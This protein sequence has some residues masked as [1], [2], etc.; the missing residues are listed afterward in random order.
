MATQGTLFQQESIQDPDVI[1]KFGITHH[2]DV[3]D[4]FSNDEI[5]K[6]Y[7]VEVI[8]S[9]WLEA[10]EASD[11]EDEYC[12]KY[13]KSLYN[14]KFT[15]FEGKQV[16]GQSEMRY[17]DDAVMNKI[18]YDFYK[19]KRVK[20]GWDE[21]SKQLRKIYSNNDLNSNSNPDARYPYYCYK[22]YIVVLLRKNS[23]GA[24]EYR[25]MMKERKQKWQENEAKLAKV[26]K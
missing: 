4:R 21:K 9:Q 3:L 6:E 25:E 20:R 2:Y 19:I 7:D 5:L 14:F 26:A 18:K 13:S 16:G 12:Q 24:K 11:V 22:F 15:L 23:R 10:Q 17:I 1:Y 8:S